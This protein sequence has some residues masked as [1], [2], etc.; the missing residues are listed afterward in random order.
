M[1]TR[2]LDI[3]MNADEPLGLTNPVAFDEMLED[4]KKVEKGTSKNGMC[5]SLDWPSLL[6]AS[7]W[8]STS[9]MISNSL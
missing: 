3:A 8:D 2:A 1:E 5:F 7:Y 4:R 9:C 6:V